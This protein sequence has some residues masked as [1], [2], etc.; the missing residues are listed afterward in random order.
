MISLHEDI[1]SSDED[2]FKPLK[3]LPEFYVV[4]GD[5]FKPLEKLPGFNVV[6]HKEYDSTSI[7]VVDKKRKLNRGKNIAQFPVLKQNMVC[8]KPL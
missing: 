4:D 7:Y 3:K 6:K 8:K 2:E 5:E 1:E